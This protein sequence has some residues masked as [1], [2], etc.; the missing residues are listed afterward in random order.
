MSEERPETGSAEA[1]S[2]WQAAI[3]F[4]IDVGQIEFLLTLTPEE[5]LVRHEQARELVRALREA[6]RQYYGFDPRDPEAADGP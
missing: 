5:R 1:R 2:A 3:D 4:G 6:G